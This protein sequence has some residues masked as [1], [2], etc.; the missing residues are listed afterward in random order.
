MVERER[1]INH[2]N[3]RQTFVAFILLFLGLLFV[4]AEAVAEAALGLT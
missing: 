4:T 2:R 1:A 3:A